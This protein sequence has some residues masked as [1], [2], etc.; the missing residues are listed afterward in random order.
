L[1]KAIC[2]ILKTKEGALKTYICKAPDQKV[3]YKWGTSKKE[4]T[5]NPQVKKTPCGLCQRQNERGRK[6]VSFNAEEGVHKTMGRGL[7]FG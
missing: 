5:M 2:G 6:A 3:T 7:L 1:Q 4:L